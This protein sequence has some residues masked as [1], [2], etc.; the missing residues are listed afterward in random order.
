[1]PRARISSSGFAS[2]AAA[3][4]SIVEM[5]AVSLMIPNHP[6]PSP[7]S[8]RSQSNVSCSSSVAAGDVFH[9]MAFVSSAAMSSSARMPGTDDEI[10]K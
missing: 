9:S 4:A 8:W 5:D 7:S 10:A 2:R 3:S 1:M 6:S